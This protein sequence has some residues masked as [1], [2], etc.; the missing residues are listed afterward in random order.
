MKLCEEQ[1]VCGWVCDP[2]SGTAS[3]KKGSKPIRI[4]VMGYSEVAQL[5]V[6]FLF[7]SF[8][9]RALFISREFFSLKRQVNA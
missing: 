7:D 9:G 2:D 5:P 4:R 8:N 3:L 1:Y 6:V